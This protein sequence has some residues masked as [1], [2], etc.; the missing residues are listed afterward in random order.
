MKGCDNAFN[1]FSTFLKMDK[2]L[3]TAILRF[4]VSLAKNS[5]SDNTEHEHNQI[6]A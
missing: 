5:N 4:R 1:H 3:K 6:L 2:K